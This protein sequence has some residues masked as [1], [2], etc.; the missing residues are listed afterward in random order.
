M[1]AVICLS[2]LASCD[3]G[4]GKLPIEPDEEESTEKVTAAERVT[5]RETEYSDYFTDGLELNRNRSTNEYSVTGYNGSS[6]VVVI[7]ETY[8]G[9]PVTSIAKNAFFKTSAEVIKLPDSI[10]EIGE[11][12]FKNAYSLREVYI[13]NNETELEKIGKDAFFSCNVLES[14]YFFGDDSAWSDVYL[15]KNWDKNAGSGTVLGTYALHIVDSDIVYTGDEIKS[16][17]VEDSDMLDSETVYYPEDDWSDSETWSEIWSESETY[18]ETMPDDLDAFVDENGIGYVLDS[19][20]EYYEVYSAVDFYGTEI[21]IPETLNGF[22]VKA[23]GQYAFIGCNDLVSISLPATIVSIGEGAFNK[24]PSL[25]T[26][27]YARGVEEWGAISIGS[28]NEILD[29]INFVYNHGR[30]SEGLWYEFVSEYQCYIVTGIGECEDED[31]FI[32]AYIDG[33]PVCEIAPNAFNW[34]N[35]R[36]VYIPET[37]YNIGQYAFGTTVEEIN[38]SENNGNFKSIDGN[39]YSNNSTLLITYAPG[40]ANTSF[41]VPY[42]VTYINS[43]AFYACNN[44]VRVTI[45]KSVTGMGE[46]AFYLCQSLESV[47]IANGVQTL[48]SYTFSNCN[49]LSQVTLG[50]GINTICYRAFNNCQSLSKLTIGKN[51]THMENEFFYNCPAL[52]AI[53]VNANNTEYSS[54]DGNLYNKDGSE[55]IKYCPGKS[56]ESFTLPEGVVYINSNSFAETKVKHVTLSSTVEYI[57]WG[58]F[59]NSALT[60]IS[61]ND[62]LGYIEGYAFEGTRLTSIYVPANVYNVGIGAFN[63]CFDLESIEV[64]YDNYYYSSEDGLLY[65]REKTTLYVYPAGKQEKSFKIPSNV[66]YIETHAFYGS[67]LETVWLPD[68]LYGMGDDAFYGCDSINLVFFYGDYYE[69]RTFQ[70]MFSE[71]VNVIIDYR[72]PSEGLTYS[73]NGEGYTVTGIGDFGG[74]ALVI[75]STYES[76][77]VTA[78][79]ENAFNDDQNIQYVYIPDSVTVIDETALVGCKSLLYIDVSE[80]NYF[81][82]SVDGVLYSYDGSCLVRYPI[83]NTRT[84]FTVPEG[85]NEI[86]KFAFRDCEH[87]REVIVGNDVTVIKD[88]AFSFCTQMKYVYIPFGVTTL[89]SGAFY[90]CWNLDNV[91]LP[92]SVLTIGEAV[93]SNCSSLTNITVGIG[94]ESIGRHFIEYCYGADPLTVNYRGGD[95]DWWNITIDGDNSFLFNAVIN[96][97]Y[98]DSGI[99][100]DGEGC[101]NNKITV[102]D[103][104]SSEEVWVKI[105]EDDGTDLYPNTDGSMHLMASGR[106]GNSGVWMLDES[107]N[108]TVEGN[109]VVVLIV[110]N[111]CTCD[112]MYDCYAM[113][114]VNM[115]ALTGENVTPSNSCRIRE[116]DICWEPYY[117]NG[118]S[119]LY[120]FCDLS[121]AGFSGRINGFSFESPWLVEGR[122]EFDIVEVAFTDTCDAAETYAESYINS[123]QNY[124]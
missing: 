49:K 119:Y 102:S 60:S 34:S 22:E 97:Y 73:F 18:S 43:E 12:A 1:A 38:V 32:P 21:V 77:P 100:Y 48:Y 2:T 27:Y 25:T 54:I 110:K 107:S 99:G 11:N 45:P 72:E 93:F 20:G 24:C 62:A 115:Y 37:V 44:L 81:Y 47:N 40:K 95:Y 66:Q 79:G 41:T 120:F 94:V 68:S 3:L 64:D 103:G 87:L 112:N 123:L 28:N 36:S 106:D 42:G 53:D 35:I 19:F 85:V 118:E 65:S 70:S 7:P 71:D 76:Y 67:S 51:V 117:V 10:R 4:M 31:I 50:S 55:L 113:E 114:T 39:L 74:T 83:G 78:I 98:S 14:I 92:N 96:Y 121:D 46:Y 124:N 61:L 111:L 105:T 57:Y 63:N 26:I 16:E 84:S 8:M 6:S 9:N 56:E 108:C 33:Y 82:K 80:D 91:V 75:P 52:S 109:G 88:S 122:C 30:V 13:G 89:D 90:G 69:W 59:R 15:G 116:L 23:I 5:E 86:C 29:K 58:A 101:Y 17:I 104:E